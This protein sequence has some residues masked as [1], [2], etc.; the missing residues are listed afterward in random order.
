MDDDP[1][2]PG[3]P[4]PGDSS[5]GGRTAVVEIRGLVKDYG[6]VRALNG[7]DLTV[8][9]GEVVGFLGPNGAGKSTTIRCLLDLLRPTGGTMRL[10]GRDPRTGGVEARRRVSYVPGEL[11]LPPRSTAGEILDSV[12][13]L[14][15]D[16]DPA[17]RADVTERLGLDPHKAAK[18]LSTGNRRKV[19]LVSAFM[20]RADLLVF[21]EPTS[22][23]DPLLQQ[24]FRDLVREAKARG[25]A[26][27]L[28]SHVLAE[29]QRTADHAVVLRQGRIVA[30]GTVD[31][32]RG[33]AAQRVEAVFPGTAPD[34]GAVPGLADIRT[35]GRRLR[36]RFTGDPAPLL[37]ALARHR[38]TSVEI[39]EP[40]LD[41]AFRDLYTPHADDTA[42]RPPEA[43][44]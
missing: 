29:V 40:D 16:C 23:L 30:R 10:F 24:V 19:A 15:G 41:D 22:G 35:D 31:D 17:R 18:G 32:L 11:R 33:N 20:S 14:R 13:R 28:S 26:V 7:I 42:A 39:A 2:D 27:L 43:H 3:A 8:H 5:P 6:R 1:T 9:A 25:T 34:L 37:D 21:D 4:S 38:P 12:A 36:A 44:A